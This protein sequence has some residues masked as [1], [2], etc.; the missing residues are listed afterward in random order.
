[1]IAL[2]VALGNNGLS[3]L[4]DREQQRF[5]NH[6]AR[7]DELE[8]MVLGNDVGTSPR[9]NSHNTRSETLEKRLDA[10]EE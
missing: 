5:Q 1:V 2:L 10:I 7:I 6:E 9:E 3:T 4:R 8:S